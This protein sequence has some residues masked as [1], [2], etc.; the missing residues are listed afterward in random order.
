MGFFTRAR[1]YG[2]V[3]LHAGGRPL[4]PLVDGFA[5][6]VGPTGPVSFGPVEL[7]AGTNEVVVELLGKDTRS[8][9]YSDGYLVGVDGFVLRPG[10]PE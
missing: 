3:R 5:P 4:E 9:G 2:I 10:R 6:A 1:G 7:H 8:A